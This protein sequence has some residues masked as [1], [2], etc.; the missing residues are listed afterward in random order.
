MLAKPYR[1]EWEREERESFQRPEFVRFQTTAGIDFSDLLADD[2]E[3]VVRAQRHLTDQ[4]VLCHELRRDRTGYRLPLMACT[5]ELNF[6][7]PRISHNLDLDRL[8]LGEELIDSLRRR[9]IALYQA[10]LP[11]QLQDLARQFK[12]PLTVL[13]LGSGGGLDTLHLLQDDPDRV[14]RVINLDIDPEAVAWGRNLAGALERKRLIPRGRIEYDCRS[15]MKSRTRGHLVLLA[16]V[17]CELSD[18]AARS[19]LRR[20]HALLPVGGRLLLSTFNDNLPE[21]SPLGA[22]LLHHLGS[23]LDPADGWTGT[24]RSRKALRGL[25]TEAGFRELTIYDDRNYPGRASLPDEILWGVDTLATTAFDL[26]HPGRPLTRSLD[27]IGKPQ[28]GCN[29]IAVAEKTA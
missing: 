6:G 5:H 7:S 17:I 12:E 3:T 8:L 20:I 29:W 21:R 10:L 13:N 2:R 23:N 26:D 9:H 14:A 11:G 22:F 4:S 16:G 28:P 1:S 19:V 18:A 15:L 27:E 24:G 25:L